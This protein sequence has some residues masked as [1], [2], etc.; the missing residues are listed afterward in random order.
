M[1]C[2]QNSLANAVSQ[3]RAVRPATERAG[4]DHGWKIALRGDI[5]YQVGL[6]EA[7]QI[8]AINGSRAGALR[9]QECRSCEGTDKDLEVYRNFYPKL[10]LFNTRHLHK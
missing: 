10:L 9:H 3:Q 7:V 2:L 5:K 4:N 6:V 8:V 1:A